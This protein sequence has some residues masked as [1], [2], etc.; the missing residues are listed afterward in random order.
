MDFIQP[1]GLRKHE[2]ALLTKPAF[3]NLLRRAASARASTRGAGRWRAYEQLK[4][5]LDGICGWSSRNPEFGPEHWEAGIRM[6]A[7]T[8]GV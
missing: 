2:A 1:Q 3:K 7:R 5:E 6:L 4:R 8:M